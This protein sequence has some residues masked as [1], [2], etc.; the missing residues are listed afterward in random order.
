MKKFLQTLALFLAIPSIA[1]MAWIAFAVIHD[2]ASYTG[3]L[4][5]PP[6]ARVAVCGD[7]QTK[8][9]LSPELFPGLFNFSTAATTCDQD[10]MRL[11]DVLAANPGRFTHAIIDA[12]PLKIGHDESRPV[13]E[14][15][16][17]RVHLL[18]HIYHLK[19]S[20]RPLGS[21][22]RLIRDVIFTRKFNEFRKSILR[23]KPWR[24]SM[25]GAF[26]PEKER[27]FLNPKLRAKAEADLAEKADRV[28][29]RPPAVESLQYFAALE[30]QVAS[31]RAAGA[32]PVFSTMPLS[33]PLRDAIDPARLAAFSG[34]MRGLAKRLDVP[35]LDFLEYDLPLECWHD[36]NHLNREGADLFTPAFRDAFEKASASVR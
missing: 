20:K 29:S 35:Y 32:K 26:A 17:A 33:R 18:L 36:G 23:G 7:S 2:R 1:G 25:A 11:Q 31:V 28:N 9:A 3:A 14:L 6:S 24:S 10:A 22:S 13:S 16:A 30:R 12:S 21:V 19:D 15:N 4:A 27:G 5:A 8:D 34:A